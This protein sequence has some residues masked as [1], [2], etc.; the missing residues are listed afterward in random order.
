MKE[1]AYFVRDSLI[2][3]DFELFGKLLSED[4]H[5]KAKFNS[6]ITTNYMR[7]LNRLVTNNGCIDGQVY[8][9]RDGVYIVLLINPHSKKKILSLLRHKKG[10]I[11][12]FKFLNKGQEIL[13]IKK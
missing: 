7:K 1:V 12:H 10:K 13:S 2:S 4:W 11:I 5:V 3:D 6:L 8:G 9:V